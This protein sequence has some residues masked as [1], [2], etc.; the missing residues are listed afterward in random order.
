MTINAPSAEL[1]EARKMINYKG[2]WAIECDD[3]VNHD[4][5]RPC[6]WRVYQEEGMCSIH[7][8]NVVHGNP[9]LLC[10]IGDEQLRFWCNHSLIHGIGLWFMNSV[11]TQLMNAIDVI[12]I[13]NLKARCGT[14]GGVWNVAG[15]LKS[16]IRVMRSLCSMNWRTDA[17]WTIQTA[18]SAAL[19]YIV[20]SGFNEF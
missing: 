10:S 13:G 14:D 5:V 11:C 7:A 12:T 18:K 16:T 20:I 17:M 15:T 19:E 1:K 9:S 4:R 6:D 3:S 8:L 2:Q